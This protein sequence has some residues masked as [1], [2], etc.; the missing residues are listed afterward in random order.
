MDDEANFRL[1]S[2]GHH[3][4][5]DSPTVSTLDG[6]NIDLNAQQPWNALAPTLTISDSTESGQFSSFLQLTKQ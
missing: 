1:E 5:H 2:E 3:R 6:R 4:K